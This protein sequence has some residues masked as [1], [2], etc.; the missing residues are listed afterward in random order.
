[1]GVN[2]SPRGGGS[3]SPQPQTP[4]LPRS[5]LSCLLSCPININL[6]EYLIVLSLAKERILQTLSTHCFFTFP[7]Q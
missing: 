4:V 5:A 2:P 3:A 6:T 7:S 1:M